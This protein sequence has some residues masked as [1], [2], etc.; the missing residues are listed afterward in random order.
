MDPSLVPTEDNYQR[1]VTEFGTALITDSLLTQLEELILARGKQLHPLLKRK[2]FF[3]HR[4]LEDIIKCLQEKKQFYLYTGRGPSSAALHLGHLI[5]FM[6]TQYLQDVFDVEVVIQLTDDEKFLSRELTYDECRH[7]A[8]ENAKDILAVGFNPKKTFIFRNTDYYGTLYPNILQLERHITLNKIQ[9]TFGFEGTD[10]IG[11]YA[12]PVA[13]MAPALST[14]FP[15][16]F[17]TQ[18]IPCLIP[19]AIDQDPFFRLIRDITPKLGYSKP[20]VLHAKYL[21]GLQGINA[22]MSAS[23]LTTAIFVT[24]TPAQIK[25]K[26][27]KYAFSGGRATKEEH[28]RLGADLSV[29]VPFHY[30]SILHPDDAKI[31]QIRQD[32]GSGKML[33]S[34]IKKELITLL[35]EIVIKH[36]DARAKITDDIFKVR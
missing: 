12:F 13:E 9:A 3:S 24:D 5:P 33:T 4:S 26:I 30:I 15:H 14:S 2:I 21:P 25:N 16:L 19:C 6:L 10:N 11:K 1:L 22:K 34:E 28:Q 7:F 29:D 8:I 35:T 36:Q 18:K 27:N 31:E 20:A 32:Y 23:D 17:G